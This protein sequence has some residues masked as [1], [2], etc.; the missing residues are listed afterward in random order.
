MPR[1]PLQLVSQL[2]D[3]V[4]ATLSETAGFAACTRCLW[5]LGDV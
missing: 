5:A 3:V 2:I 4:S 1:M